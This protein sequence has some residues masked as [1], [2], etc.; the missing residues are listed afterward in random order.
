MRKPLFALAAVTALLPLCLPMACG[1]RDDTSVVAVTGRIEG[2]TV[3][4]GSRIGGRVAEVPVAEGDSVAAGDVL[5]RLEATEAQAGVAAA[6]AALDQAKAALEKLET[7]ARSEE[8]RQAQA[9]VDQADAV[10]RMA[11]EG[12]RRQD[13]ESARA[14]LEAA[15]GVEKE[16]ATS[17]E[18]A[19]ALF[20]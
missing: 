17:F 7:G 13:I 6:Q 4:P 3:R 16:A 5:V 12:A 1:A 11:L 2:M 9:M 10:Y 20:E 18:R 14:A 8:I 15:V 19:Q